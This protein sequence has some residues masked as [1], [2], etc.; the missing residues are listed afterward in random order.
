MRWIVLV[1]SALV[2]IGFSSEFW[3]DFSTPVVTYLISSLRGWDGMGIG[4]GGKFGKLPG[5]EIAFVRNIADS[6][7]IDYLVMKPLIFH[8]S[9]SDLKVGSAFG[10]VGFGFDVNLKDMEFL[11]ASNWEMNLILTSGLGAEFSTK[12]RSGVFA[13][14]KMEVAIR[15]KLFG[16]IE[17]SPYYIKLFGPV[18][19]RPL[20]ALG[21]R[22]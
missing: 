7:S 12:G 13:R 10:D 16:E 21:G 3:F 1:L 2:V 6:S 19:T 17:E 22:F 4:V 14:I 18:Y 9:I 15:I 20:L 11:N 5:F 8:G